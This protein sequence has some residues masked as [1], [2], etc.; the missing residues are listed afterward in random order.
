M[1][2]FWSVLVSVACL[3][4]GQLAYAQS[5]VSR[6]DQIVGSAAAPLNRQ[7]TVS[8]D[9]TPLG[10]ALRD[11]AKQ[12]GARISYPNSLVER[13]PAVTYKASDVTAGSAFN[14]ILGNT[15]L[16]VVFSG[17]QF[18]VVRAESQNGKTAQ[19]VIAGRVTD[20]KSGKGIAGVN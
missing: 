15:G 9:K 13:R 1:K 18:V 8:F 14:S 11:V 6:A 10:D 12:T 19:G 5:V 4:S 16:Q 7:V 2:R 3:V 20:A 17:G